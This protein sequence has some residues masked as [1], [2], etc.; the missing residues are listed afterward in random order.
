[1]ILRAEASLENVRQLL[2]PRN[3]LPGS[4]L[5]SLRNQAFATMLFRMATVPTPSDPLAISWQRTHREDFLQALITGDWDDAFVV[6]KTDT[7][8]NRLPEPLAQ[9]WGDNWLNYRSPE[10]KER[11]PGGTMELDH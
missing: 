3:P 6:I 8:E 7:S 1:M 10:G 4:P 2:T 11:P 9:I 5:R